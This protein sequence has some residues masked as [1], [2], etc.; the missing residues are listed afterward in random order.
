MM[1]GKRP[2]FSCHAD[3]VIEIGGLRCCAGHDGLQTAGFKKL[4]DGFRSK[5]GQVFGRLEMR[6]FLS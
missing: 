5:A 4:F 3:D 6:P 1:D 2:F